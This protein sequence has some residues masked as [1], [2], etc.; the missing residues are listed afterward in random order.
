[1]PIPVSIATVLEKNEIASSTAILT[2]LKIEI[3]DEITRT[4]PETFYIVQNDEDLSFNG[5]AYTAYPFEFEMSQSGGEEPNISLTLKD[6]TGAI[7]QKMNQ[8]AGA[9]QSLVT[10]M[11]VPANAIAGPPEVSFTFRVLTSSISDFDVS[12][13]LGNKNHLSTKFPRR[14]QMKDR[15]SWQYKSTDCGYVGV[16][17]S[18]DY[19]L[20]GPNG[21]SAHNNSPNFGGFPGLNG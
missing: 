19:S 1:M 11:L 4:F 10:V 9:V 17:P 16:M 3:W 8:Y 12:W 5:Q 15:C 18:C 20:Q 2:L 13:E 14:T 6:V 21:C 7:K